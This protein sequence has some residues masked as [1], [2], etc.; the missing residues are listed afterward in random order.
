MLRKFIVAAVLACSLSAQAAERITFMVG[1]SAASSLANNTRLLCQEMNRIQNKYEFVAEFKPG[2]GGAIGSNYVLQNPKNTI[3]VGSSTFFLRSNF[4][5]ATGYDIDSFQGV[6][7]QVIGTPV[8]LYSSKYSS[9]S[10]LRQSN[11]VST[12]IS[13]YGSHSNLLSTILANTGT[14]VDI[15]NYPSLVDATKDVSGKHLDSSWNWLND[16]EPQVEAGKTKILAITGTRS[17]NGYPTFASLGVKGF[18]NVSAS[19]GVY[20]SAEMPADRVREMYEIIKQAHR[21]SEIQESYTKQYFTTTPEM[22]F[23]ETQAWY[24]QQARFWRDQAAKVKPLQ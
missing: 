16:V 6:F 10:E 22:S 4:D 18:E 8:A 20:A 11:K 15:I 24:R 23:A 7:V 9:L 21:N 1:F 17:I 12:G 14:T 5:R 13:G 19:Y 2:A 3:T